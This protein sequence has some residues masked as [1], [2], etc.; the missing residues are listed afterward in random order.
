M[1]S[2]KRKERESQKGDDEQVAKKARTEESQRTTA[3]IETL[4]RKA[5][6]VLDQQLAASV[7]GELNDQDLTILSAAQNT[8][9]QRKLLTKENEMKRASMRKISLGSDFYADDWDSRLVQ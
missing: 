4:K 7:K 2:K 9:V 8:E 5:L 3:Q 6:G 1:L